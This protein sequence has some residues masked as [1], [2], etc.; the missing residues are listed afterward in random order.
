M[1]ESCELAPYPCGYAKG[2]GAP[3]S[4]ARKG[5]ICTRRSEG[6]SFQRRVCTQRRYTPARPAISVQSLII[7]ERE[8]V[9]RQPIHAL[10]QLAAEVLQQIQAGTFQVGE[11]LPSV[12]QISRQKGL[13]VTTVLQ[14]YHLLEDRGAI[15]ARPQSGYYV[16][17]G[18]CRPPGAAARRLGAALRPGARAHRRP[19]DAGG[20]RHA[21]PGPD[22]VRRGAARPRPAA[23]RRSSTPSWP[24][25]RASTRADTTAGLPAGRWNCARRSPGGP[26]W[27][28]CALAPDDIVITSGGTEAL[29]LALRAVCKP[30]DLVAIE[31]PTYFGILQVLRSRSGCARWK[32]PPTRRRASAWSALRFALDHHPVR[33]AVVMTQFQQPAG[34]LHARP[35]T[36][37]RWWRCWRPP[38]SR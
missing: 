31:S 33:A 22:P 8:P 6:V 16:R 37:A 15:E 2:A 17:V 12:R 24:R 10:R 9:R 28:G 13:S 3:H 1:A 5:M 35:R 7:H 36:S 21:Q 4:S 34:Q 20:A 19:G 14:A 26:S 38:R 27:H 29:H 32:S 30:G 18:R 25:S 11:R 23:H